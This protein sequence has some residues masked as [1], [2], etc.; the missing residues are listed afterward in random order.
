LSYNIQDGEAEAKDND[1]TLQ[2]ILA[3][4]VFDKYQSD[5]ESK[6]FKKAYLFPD[7]IELLII[8]YIKYRCDR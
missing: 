7:C 5:F 1:S 4:V 6:F 2:D 3:S 8:Y